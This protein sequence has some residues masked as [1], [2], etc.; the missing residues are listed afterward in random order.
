LDGGPFCLGQ[1]GE[2]KIRLTPYQSLTGDKGGVLLGDFI[3]KFNEGESTKVSAEA[4]PDD[5]P[6]IQMFVGR[7]FSNARILGD[8]KTRPRQWQEIAADLRKEEDAERRSRLIRELDQSLVKEDQK[9]RRIL[10]VNPGL[11]VR[12]RKPVKG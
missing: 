7:G 9:D 6:R 5:T 4:H 11:A 10:P 8:G 2:S 12:G 1:L 3:S